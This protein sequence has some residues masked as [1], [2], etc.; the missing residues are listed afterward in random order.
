VATKL[1]VPET[2]A[3]MQ[4]IMDTPAKAAEWIQAG[5]FSEIV[6]AYRKA[7]TPE[8]AEQVADQLRAFFEGQTIIE[9][10]VDE[11]FNRLL[12]EHG[13]TRPPLAEPVRGTGAELNAAYNPLAWGVK[14]NDLGFVNLGDFARAIWHKN[15]RPDERLVEARKVMD[16][17]SSVEPSAG[18]FLI[19]ETMRAEIMELALEQSIVRPR[20]TVITM[21]SLS[22]IMPYVDATTNVGSVFGGMVFYWTEEGATPTITNAKFGRI[23]LEANKLMGLAAI[24]NE[25]WADAPALSSWLTQAMPRG[26]AFYEDVAFLAGNGAGQPLGVL[27]STALVAITKETDQPADTIVVENVLKMYSRMLPSSL[28]NAVWLANPTTFPELMQLSISV[29]VGGAPVALVDIRAAPMATM[30]GRPLI[31]T[32]KVPTLGDQ[33]DLAFVDLGYYL[34]GD[35]QA[36]SMETSEHVYFA[37][38][39]TALRIIE[40][41]D[42][43]PWIQSAFTPLNGSTVSPFVAIEARA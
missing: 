28:G 17:Y 23:R 33:G 18:G 41:V 15:P 5:Q 30:L 9:D 4:E 32:E 39:E 8:F 19:P 1:V 22:Q 3:Q 6:D 29:G 42:G 24:P 34:V 12:K 7:T 31:L 21:G 38:D 13:V 40:R 14:M 2:V 37:N 43:R 20:A 36:V 16:A 26:I 10:K 25:L 27:E 35:R 11:T